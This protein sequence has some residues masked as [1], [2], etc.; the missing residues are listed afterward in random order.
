MYNMCKKFQRVFSNNHHHDYFHRWKENILIKVLKQ[1]KKTSFAKQIAED[2]MRSN[3]ASIKDQQTACVEKFIVK[4][5]KKKIWMRW[6][7]RNFR[8]DQNA[9]KDKFVKEGIYAIHTKRAVQK[10]FHRT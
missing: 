2:T 3:V 10:W 8:Q 7:E 1:Q 4:R 6:T 5:W 9:I